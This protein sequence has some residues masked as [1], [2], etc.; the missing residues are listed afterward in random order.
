[1]GIILRNTIIF[2]ILIIFSSCSIIEYNM[3]KRYNRTNNDR[4]KTGLW[5]EFYANGN[6]KSIVSY[7][8]GLKNGIFIKYH[9]NGVVEIKKYYKK[10]KLHGIA[11][12]YMPDGSIM[13]R[14]RFS[15]GESVGKSVLSNP[16]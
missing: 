16:L 6:K 5:L 11:K 2:L 14:H 7:K 1:M 12:Y 8:N 9:E 15:H 3:S 10:D 4:K 13:S